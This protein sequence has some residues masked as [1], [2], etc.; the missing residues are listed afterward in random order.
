M[1]PVQGKI[2]SPTFTTSRDYSLRFKLKLASTSSGWT[3]IILF[4]ANGRDCCSYGDRI[5]AIWVYPSSSSL[6]IIMGNTAD[7]NFKCSE[8]T[9]ALELNVWHSIELYAIGSTART[10]FDGAIEQSCTSGGDRPP[11]TAVVYAS[12]PSYAPAPALVSSL[13]YED[14]TGHT[15]SICG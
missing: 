6:H 4:S 11:A 3:S 10:F 9:R 15:D 7:G 5:P 12:S 13:L 14:L 1:S 2:L 8:W